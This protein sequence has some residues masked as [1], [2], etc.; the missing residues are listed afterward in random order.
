MF[1]SYFRGGSFSASFNMPDSSLSY[2]LLNAEVQ[3][4]VVGL[5][6]FSTQA[7]SLD[8]LNSCILQALNTIFS[9]A[10]PKL[11]CRALSLNCLFNIST[12][13]TNRASPILSQTELLILPQ[14]SF[15][16]AIHIIFSISANGY[17]FCCAG[18][19]LYG[20]VLAPLLHS[21][22]TSSPSVNIVDFTLN[23]WPE[24]NHFF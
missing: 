20:V 12:R 7:H 9:L 17:S 1:Y 18:L 10:A 8:N 23:T 14:W 22:F 15:K 2:R 13:M 3:G 6:L 11:I 19:K 16:Y 21:W 4:S 24:S 5:L